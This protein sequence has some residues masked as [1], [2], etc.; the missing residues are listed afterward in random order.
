MSM[1]LLKVIHLYRRLFI[2]L[3]MIIISF[4]LRAEE[5]DVAYPYIISA[6]G[7]I[8]YD[9]QE[10]V[11]T[12][13][14]NTRFVIEDLEI[15]AD[16]LMI[17]YREELILAEGDELIFQAGGQTFRG[18]ALEYNYREG[19]G[20]IRK[21]AGRF[22]E[23]SIAGD[24]IRFLETD[25]YQLQK[26][27]L[28]PC[29]LPQPHYSLKAREIIVYPE[30]RIIARNLWFY[31]AGKKVFYLPTYTM[32]FDAEKEKYD[33]VFLISDLGY[34]SKTGFFVQA[35]YP[36]EIGENF[37]GEIIGELN[38]EGGTYLRMDNVYSVSPVLDIRNQYLYEDRINPEGDYVENNSLGVGLLY[39]NRGLRL[40][41][42]VKK[43]YLMDEII[44]DLDGRY[45]R[46]KFHYR[47]FN[48][49]KE[50]GLVKET[51]SI[52]YRGKYP[53]QLMYRKGYSVD[54]L[55]YLKIDGLNYQVAGV[56]INSGLGIGKVTNKE[57]SSDRLRLD[58]NLGKT[59]VRNDSFN[60]RVNTALQGNYYRTE[61]K[62]T[63]IY[64]YLQVGLNSTYYEDISPKLRLRAELKYDY[65]V[66]EGEAYIAEDRIKTGEKIR[67]ALG[68]TYL[69]PEKYSA[70]HLDL[71]GSYELRNKELEKMELKITREH[72]CYDYFLTID[73]IEKGIGIGINF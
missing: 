3:F 65:S 42:G 69:Q 68:L 29:I 40:S 8:I 67:P 27:E 2:I 46:G 41:T 53:L 31:F 15:L 64:N 48:E 17:Y 54:Y 60:L 47:Y 72:D 9:H 21:P 52:D 36:Y 13:S 20:V 45:T 50:E 49:F 19:T 12:A 26:V 35:T 22:N 44:L 61:D 10:G 62:D 39:N 4:T 30:E 6:D 11:L 56:S 16:K 73:L 71:N 24:E 59:L 70:W 51:Y 58:M 7:D 32:K 38:Q 43:D 33:S 55:P 37:K 57:N 63:V 1:I 34:D 18:K 25:N 66:D 14:G 28:T 23:L 5:I